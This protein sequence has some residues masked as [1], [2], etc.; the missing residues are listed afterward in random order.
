MDTGVGE[1][2]CTREGVG[3]T[4]KLGR[5]TNLDLREKK[6]GHPYKKIWTRNHKD[7]HSRIPK[8]VSYT[9][10]FRSTTNVNIISPR[11]FG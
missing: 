9:S 6:D 1:G 2:G 11:N 10:S 4:K 8:C 3:D 5:D 7:L